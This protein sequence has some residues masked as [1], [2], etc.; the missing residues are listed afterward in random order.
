MKTVAVLVNPRAG[1]GLTVNRPGSD[2]LASYD[3]GRSPTVRTAIEFLANIRDMDIEIVSCD[4]YMGGYELRQA[5]ISRFR[6]VY[7]DPPI[8]ERDDTVNFIRIINGIPIDLLLFFGGDGTA[9]D[10]SSVIDENITVIGIPAGVKMHSAVFAI[11]PQR[12]LATM[13]AFLGVG[14]ETGFEDVVD[15]DEENLLAG[16]QVLSVKGRLR[17]PITEDMIL[18]SKREYSDP[19][20]MGAIEYIQERLESEMSYI[21]GPGSTCKLISS[22][23]GESPPVYGIDVMRGSVMVR[24]NAPMDFLDEYTRKNRCRLILTPIGGQGIL[25]GRGNRQL[26]PDVISRIA[27]EDLMVVSS[28]EKLSGLKHVVIQ[29]GFCS[30]RYIKILYG[31]G[32]FRAVPVVRG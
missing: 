12:A 26:T 1:Y 19:S 5:G 4:N 29:Y 3:P 7:S 2:T 14:V 6:V 11:S 15:A 28:F 18:E 31:Y 23:S 22:I 32:R 21:I 27:D 24:A 10:I 8:S 16:K 17:V 9:S 30:I 25:I 20:V 13:R